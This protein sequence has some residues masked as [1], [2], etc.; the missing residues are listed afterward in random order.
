MEEF[1][2]TIPIPRPT[3]Y[4]IDAEYPEAAKR[5]AAKKHKHLLPK[6]QTWEIERLAHCF[7]V[8]PRSSGRSYKE[9]SFIEEAYKRYYG[10]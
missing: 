7:R 10:E 9:P 8:N 1:R 6:L 4:L 2:V 5:K 3:E